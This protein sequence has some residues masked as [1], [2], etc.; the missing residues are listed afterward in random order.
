MSIFYERRETDEQIELEFKFLPL[1][2]L[3]FFGM[4]AASL[5]PCGWC[6]NRTVRLCGVLLLLWM[7]GLLPVWM[8]LEAAMR[9]GSVVVSGRKF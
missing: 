6:A 3:L 4:I 2:N 5:S 1:A 7:A 8:E 9:S